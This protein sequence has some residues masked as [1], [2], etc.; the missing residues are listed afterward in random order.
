MENTLGLN[1]I[2]SIFSLL[3]GIMF[4]SGFWSGEGSLM[5]GL[6]ID[7]FLFR[8]IKDKRTF[9]SGDQLAFLLCA[10]MSLGIFINGILSYVVP[11]TPNISAIFLFI[12]V[13]LSWPIRIIFLFLNYGKRYEDIPR[14]W[15]FLKTKKEKPRSVL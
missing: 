1:I 12:A 14:I 13:F 6:N 5:K 15:P 2:L 4:V 11:G 10:C 8:S 3:L 9:K 7:K